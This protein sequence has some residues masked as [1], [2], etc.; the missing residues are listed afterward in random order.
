MKV[1]FA[2]TAQMM[3][4]II[5]FSTEMKAQNDDKTI[6]INKDAVKSIQFDFNQHTEEHFKQLKE[7]TNEKKW[8]EYKVDLSVPRNWL[9]TT[10]IEKPKDYVRANPYT[11][12]TQ[13][14]E[15]P[16]YDVLVTGRPKGDNMEWELNP[17]GGIPDE[18]G[19]FIRPLPGKMYDWVM[20]GTGGVGIAFSFDA[21]KLLTEALTARGRMLKHNR[22]YAVAWKTYAQ[23]IPTKQDSLQFPTYL[24]Y[25]KRKRTTDTL[26]STQTNIVS[27]PARMAKDSLSFKT[28][29][30][31]AP[32][33]S[34]VIEARREKR[35][36]AS[37]LY[38][39]MRIKQ[40]RDSIQRDEILGRNPKRQ[41]VYE[42]DK[43]IRKLKEN[44]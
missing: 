39:E 2:D 18:Y 23:R 28:P 15:D 17:N 16:V 27:L 26:T 25:E 11:I 24:A 44:D 34:K 5:F 10:K 20:N 40:R 35:E 37:S 42:L 7:A 29:A 30:G 31:I 38:E 1:T 36:K 32:A 21:N 43:Q 33:L 19:R 41:N 9:D 13:F 14:G 3:L 4:L 6:R 12:W 22:K 8:L